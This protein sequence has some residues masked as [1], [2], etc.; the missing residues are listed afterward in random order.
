MG[1]IVKAANMTEKPLDA[2]EMAFCS[3]EE[4]S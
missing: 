1:K 2:T 3:E 4:T